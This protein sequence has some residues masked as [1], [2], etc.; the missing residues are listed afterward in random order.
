MKY[1][2]KYLDETFFAQKTLKAAKELIGCYLVRRIGKKIE[3]YKITETEAYIGPHDLAS[4]SSK[5][6]TK[7]TEV[8][9][10]EPGTIYIYMIYGMY[11]MLNIVTEKKDFPAAILI[12]GA[13]E[14]V[15]PGRLAKALEID[16]RLNGLKAIPENG[17]W[18]E[19]RDE[20]VDEKIA[21]IKIKKSKR[22]GVDYAGP[23]WAEKEYRFVLEK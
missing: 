22:V 17:L 19:P 12:R 4:H 2:A 5:G 16:K 10:A 20:P 18:F 15:G 1:T 14:Y 11:F 6:R 7:R 21:K 9:F 13:G 8:M 23:I 3:R